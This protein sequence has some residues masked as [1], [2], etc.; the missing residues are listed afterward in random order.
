MKTHHIFFTLL[1]MLVVVG[2]GTTLRAQCMPNASIQPGFSSVFAGGISSFGVVGPNDNGDYLIV[3][4][5]TVPAIQSTLSLLPLPNVANQQFCDTISVAP[6]ALYFS[7]VPTAAERTGNFSA[8]A[9]QLAGVPGV[10]AGQ[11]SLEGSFW[12]WRIPAQLRTR[13][14]VSEDPNFTPSLLASEL[15]FPDGVAFRPPTNE[16]DLLVSLSGR[17]E[18][19]QVSRVDKAG[20]VGPFIPA[21]PFADK[22]ARSSSASSSNTGLIAVATFPLGSIDFYDAN[23]TFLGS[24]PASAIPVPGPHANVCGSV[25]FDTSGN[26]LVAAGPAPSEGSCFTSL[27]GNWAIYEFQGP[28]PWTATESVSVVFSFGT[29]SNVA[30]SDIAFTAAPPPPEGCGTVYALESSGNL[31]MILPCNGDSSVVPGP[32]VVPGNVAAQGIAVD[33][34]LG[35]VYIL[36]FGGTSIVRVPASGGAATTFATGF[37]NTLRAAFDPSGNLYVTEPNAGNLWKFTR[38]SNAP[39]AQPIFPGKTN[40]LTFQNPAMPDQTETVVIP[41]SANIDGAAFLQVIFVQEDPAT[42][43]LRLAKGSRG[44]TGF[45]GGSSVPPGTTCIPIPSAT[46][47]CVVTVQKCFDSK[48]NAFDIC[49]VQEPSG[50]S[51]LIQL[52]FSYAAPTIPPNPAFLIDFDNPPLGDQTLT[53]ITDGFSSND[54]VVFGGTKGICSQTVVASR[55]APQGPDFSLGSISPITLSLGGS[56]TMHLDGKDE[57]E[58]GTDCEIRKR[59]AE[60]REQADRAAGRLAAVVRGEHSRRHGDGCADGESPAPTVTVNSINGFTSTVNLGLSDV[61][62]GVSALFGTTPTASVTPPSNGSVSSTL[63]VSLGPSVTP[64]MFT[65]IVTG[66]APPS[67]F[68]HLTSVIV[69]VSATTSGVSTVIGD[70]LT[71]GCIDSA[72][73]AHALTS[74]LSA[75]QRAIGE[76]QIQTAVNILTSFQNQVRAQTGKH[77]PTSC[78]IGGI[79]FNPANALLTDAQSLIDSL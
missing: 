29:E 27:T 63:N 43:D 51:D 2:S 69:T 16:N 10:T 12:G 38:A 62:T 32:S 37:T 79:T 22:V 53:D 70:L 25:A 7:Y 45:F 64:S 9:T 49:P 72:G 67:Q 50:S 71:S 65:L 6:G 34:L 66:N 73:I 56:T 20:H 14:V 59:Q 68:D 48:G 3:G 15:S 46:G 54:P 36:E 30:I 42:L 52:S 19:G 33:P 74:R 26:L 4:N 39:P 47:N 5:T 58:H 24:I 57:N 18:S 35:D 1:M 78:T 23:A 21:L 44:D 11:F 17:L 55:G 61:P 77:I 76:G 31:D 13:T 8:F 41:A 60:E 28:T 75:A 40:T